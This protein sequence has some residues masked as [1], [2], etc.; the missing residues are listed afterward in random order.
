MGL[1]YIKFSMIDGLFIGLLI[2]FI[3]LIV[4]IVL[5]S[6]DELQTTGKVASLIILG[7]MAGVLAFVL[8]NILF[9]TYNDSK[10]KFEKDYD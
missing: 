10:K 3:I 8:A 9:S 5:I 2:I 4:L 7:I 1:I 6:I